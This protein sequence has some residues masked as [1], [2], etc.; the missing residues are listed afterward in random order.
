[1]PAKVRVPP[2]LQLISN[3]K[4]PIPVSRICLFLRWFDGGMRNGFLGEGGKRGRSEEQGQL[5]HHHHQLDHPITRISNASGYPQKGRLKPVLLR[6]C[7][8]QRRFQARRHPFTPQWDRDR[9]RGRVAVEDGRWVW[10]REGQ[11]SG[12][13]SAAPLADHSPFRSE[14]QNSMERRLEALEISAY[15]TKWSR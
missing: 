15:F 12:K 8:Y 7:T 13:G 10:R 4:I 6:S 5:N 11:A 14:T 1:M 2:P 9:L 3:P